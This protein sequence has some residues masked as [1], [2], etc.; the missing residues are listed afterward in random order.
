MGESGFRAALPR[1]DERPHRD[2]RAGRK[3]MDACFRVYDPGIGRFV[4]SDPLIDAG[5]Q[6]LNRYRYDVHGWTSAAEGR[7]R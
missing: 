2:V 3:R 5:V 7:T 1:A 6:G 4:Q